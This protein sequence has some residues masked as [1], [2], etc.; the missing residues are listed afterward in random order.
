MMFLPGILRP[1]GMM[2][3]F[4][5]RLEAQG[6]AGAQIPLFSAHI[7]FTM[8]EAGKTPWNTCASR[9]DP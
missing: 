9:N 2:A 6:R 1:R 5:E 8:A 3:I 7:P 4:W